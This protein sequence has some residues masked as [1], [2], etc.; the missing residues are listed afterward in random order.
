M[1]KFLF[2]HVFFIFLMYML[3][4]ENNMAVAF[5]KKFIQHLTED[6]DQRAAPQYALI[7]SPKPL[8]RVWVQGRGYINQYIRAVS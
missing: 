7:N 5:K 6:R 8:C 1:Y 3:L 4:T 2:G